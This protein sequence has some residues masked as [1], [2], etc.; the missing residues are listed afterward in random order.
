MLLVVGRSLS[1]LL[2]CSSARSRRNRARLCLVAGWILCMQMLDMYIIVLPALHGT[3]VHVRIW[4]LLSLI[5]IGATL[6]SFIC[7]LCL[8]LLSFRSAIRA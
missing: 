8:G 7:E 4:D 5:A 3:G 6:V 1:V 2:S